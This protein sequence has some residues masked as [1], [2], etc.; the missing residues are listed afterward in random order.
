MSIRIKICGVTDPEAA[1]RAVESGA[2]LIGLNFVPDSPR[3]LDLQTAVAI[4]ERIAGQAERV[5]VFKD[6]TPEEIERVLRR[7]D[8]ERV[9]LHG[10]ETNLALVTDSIRFQAPLYPPDSC[11]K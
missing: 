9:Q 8:L 3:Y 11:R 10:D 2:N 1:E 4:S 6:A 7:V 5:A